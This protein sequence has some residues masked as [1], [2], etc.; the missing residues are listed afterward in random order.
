MQRRRLVRILASAIGFATLPG[1]RATG[2]QRPWRWRGAA[3]GAQAR[4]DLWLDDPAQARR[5][6][7]LCL[8]EIDR[9]ERIFSLQRRD[10]DLVR[11]NR[12]GALLRPPLELVAVLETAARVAGRTDGAFD[13]TVQP[14]WRLHADHFAR[15]G[16]DPVGPPARDLERLRPLVDHRALEVEPG[17]V[18]LARSGMAVTLNGIAQGFVADRLAALLQDQGVASVLLDVGEIATVG[19]APGGGDWRVRAGGPDGPALDL[20]RG[21]VATSSPAALSFD[22]GGRFSHLLDPATLRPSAHAAEVTVVADSATLADAL[23]TALSVRP[24]LARTASLGL[25][26]VRAVL[27]RPS[28]AAA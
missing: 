3:L 19:A 1:P 21:A 4:I 28:P 6:V 11:L 15:P 7:G 8:A 9:L 16:R 22:G 14:L 25:D 24:T 27:Q 10:S 12:D 20:A 13:V 23:S 18:R 26:G 5:L 17:R 2:A